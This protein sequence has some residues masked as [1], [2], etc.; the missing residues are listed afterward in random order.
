MANK[1]IAQHQADVDKSIEHFKEDAAS[2]R[3]GRANPALVENIQV[4]S[5]GT[6][7]PLKQ[8]SSISVPESRVLVIEPWDK[9]I[10]KAIEKA[11]GNANL[12]FQ[13]VV[14]G[15]I[16]R[17]TLPQ[18]TEDNRTDLVKILKDKLEAAKVSVRSI[19]EKIKEEIVKAEK[20]KE[21]T[22]DDKFDFLKELDREI[23]VW[24]K[25]LD[26]F[27]DAKEKEIMTV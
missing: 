20:N 9:S 12:G 5:Y 26:D 16:V 25:K 22:E 13:G 18:M 4:E 27:G 1:Y 17:I 8:V 23:E 7:T 3:T 19:R 2:L 21:L 14:D 11:I 24:N 15:T 10:L 6:M